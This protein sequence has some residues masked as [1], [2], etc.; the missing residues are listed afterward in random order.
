MSS[1]MRKQEVKQYE[2]LIDKPITE[3]RIDG[4]E[5]LEKARTEAKRLAEKYNVEVRV[6]ELVGYY[7]PTIRWV[8]SGKTYF[9][10]E[11]ISQ[12]GEFPINPEP[13][14]PRCWKD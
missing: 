10:D 8:D 5:S 9:V 2:V 14:P 7:R 11:P 3:V 4:F 1:L 12:K 13:Y 6:V